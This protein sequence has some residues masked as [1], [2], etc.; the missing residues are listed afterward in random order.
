MPFCQYTAHLRGNNS[1]PL[2][3]FAQEWLQLNLNQNLCYPL[4]VHQ[5]VTLNITPFNIPRST[6]RTVPCQVIDPPRLRYL[7]SEKLYDPK[8]APLIHRYY[9]FSAA[10]RNTRGSAR[11]PR[12]NRT[13]PKAICGIDYAL[14]RPIFFA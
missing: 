13:T 6:G 3:D 14:P 9:V 4:Q 2:L 10:E 12:Q 11:T 5:Y 8:T 7:G 1:C